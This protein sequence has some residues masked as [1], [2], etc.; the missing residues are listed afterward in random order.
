MNTSFRFGRIIF[1]D[2]Y[3]HSGRPHWRGFL[4]N[5]TLQMGD[6]S[7]LQDDYSVMGGNG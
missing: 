6:L 4:I 5:I 3:E 1:K 2:F 7:F